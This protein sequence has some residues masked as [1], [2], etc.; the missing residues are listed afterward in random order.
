MPAIRGN[1][2]KLSQVLINILSNAIDAVE[3]QGDPERLRVTV[4]TEMRRRDGKDYAVL[5]VSDMGIGISAD[6]ADRIF[7]P[8][9][10]TKPVGQGTGLGLFI[11]RNL[12][13]E[14]KGFLE[15]AH[16]E[17]QGATFSIVLP[18]CQE[19]SC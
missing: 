6:I 12:I 4:T 5:H 9:F 8:F 13:Q 17:G 16:P 7:D 11:C 1:I 14:H 10:T 2:G 19:E 18:A 3:A 15:V